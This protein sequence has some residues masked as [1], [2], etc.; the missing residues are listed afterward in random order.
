MSSNDSEQYLRD[1]L[2][3]PE[4]VLSGSFKVELSGGFNDIAERVDEYVVTDQLEKSFRKALTIVRESV[5][6]NSANAAYLHGSFGS[7]KSH[8][9]TVLHAIL[10]NHPTARA[11]PRLRPVI[12]DNDT[13]LRDRKFLMVPYHLVGSSTL[14]SAILGGYVNA[15]RTK[16]PDAL[17]PPV[18]RADSM[19]EDARR[20]RGAFADDTK[21][22]AWLGDAAGPGTATA[23]ASGPTDSDDLDNLDELDVWTPADLD[24]AFVAPPGDRLRNALVSALLSGPLTSYSR[25]ALG[26]KDAFL[27]LENGLAIIAEHAKSLGYDGLILFLDELIL[28]LQ[29]HLSNREMVNVEVNKLVKLIESS[30]GQRALPIVSFISRQRDLSKLIGVDVVGAEV[31]NLEQQVHYL[32]ERIDTIQLEDRNLPAIVK[33]RVLK[34]RHDAGAAALAT[35]FARVESS[36]QS[37]RDVLL[38]SAGATEADWEDFRSLYPFSPALL[39]VL[40][41][42]SGALQRERT[43]LRLLKEMLHR[44]RDDMK[45]GQLIPIGDLWDVLSEGMTEAFTDQLRKEAEQATNFHA[46]VREFLIAKYDSEDDPRFK[47]DDRFVKTLLLAYLAPQVPALTRLTGAR[48]GALNHGEI[49]SRTGQSG[50]MVISRL[51]ELQ[52]QFSAELRSEG[53]EDPVFTLHLSDLDVEPLLEAEA[54]ANAD[55]VG[56]RKLWVQNQLWKELDLKKG[57]EFVTEKE[58]IWHG[59]RRVAEFVFENVANP[60]E[61]PDH[62][63]EPSV[64]GRIRFV[65]DYPFD[66][67]NYPSADASRVEGLRRTGKDAATLVWLPSFVSPQRAA[68]LGRLLKIEYLLLRDRIKDLAPNRS[69]DDQVRMKHQLEAQRETLTLAL[70]AVLKQAYAIAKPEEGNLGAEVPE[71]RHIYS[72][73]KNHN[74]DE[75]LGG[76]G[77]KL[78]ML[79]LADGMFHELY[80]KHPN[81][82]LRNDRKVVTAAQFKK[83]YFWIAR[84]MEDG[85]RRV[86]VDNSDLLLVKRVVHALELGEVHDGPLNVGTD[87]RR[88]ID[89]RAGAHGRHGD[90]PVEEIREWIDK[91]LEWSGLDKIVGNLLI[92]SYAL[93]ADRSWVLNKSPRSAPEL[94]QIG[95]GWALRAQELP[96]DEEFA[97]GHARAAA[98]FGA[99]AKPVPWARNVQALALEVREQAAAWEADVNGLRHSLDK[100]RARLGVSGDAPTDREQSVRDAADLLARIAHQH[101]A[102]ALVRELA[103]TSYV[104]TDVVLGNAMSS[105]KQV[106]AALDSMDWELLIGVRGLT[107]REDGLSDR[108]ERLLSQV[109]DTASKHEFDAHL[110]PILRASRSTA[111]QL[112]TEASRLASVG[113]MVI[114]PPPPLPD[115]PAPEPDDVS[116]TE[117]GTPAIS[118]TT[119][120]DHVPDDDTSTPAKPAQVGR[121]R[122]VTTSV[123]QVKTALAQVLT[124]VQAEI[125]AFAIA[126][127][128]VEIEINWQVR[129]AE[130]EH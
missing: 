120:R 53:V 38:D 72:L 36:N 23:D 70:Q 15:V 26:D 22:I 6:T 24:R 51:R 93:I 90:L 105:A 54:V 50:Q 129:G 30:T 45:L 46:K 32:A 14:D 121:V 16:H 112:I 17:V 48:L 47:A 52:G 87:W 34:P 65:I 69:A 27:P 43:G 3:L 18:Y 21:F 83:V 28:W 91:D 39:N 107:N 103:S 61:L 80:P 62:Q 76:A 114:D 95:P 118:G 60:T 35:A 9:M 99:K 42:L 84:A 89:Q 5:R 71:G 19:L 67:N 8:F 111:V 25:G 100:H 29:A 96:S 56:A 58:I 85:T 1:V 97:A 79:K 104:S 108:A 86:V 116:L 63:F 125:D 13:W 64:N 68:Q 88:R 41:A 123:S 57:D 66:D 74:P 113:R 130:S 119:D 110:A 31:K 75:P 44:R 77:F 37:V 92:A 117:H 109:T 33:E 59:T 40:V 55:S 115:P 78:A 94:D 128:A 12:A 127:P 126:N 101:E 102:T 4:A 106:L 73:R 98:L 7:G 2:D 49:R 124:D 82:D 11:K 20:T 81:F 10:S 122:R